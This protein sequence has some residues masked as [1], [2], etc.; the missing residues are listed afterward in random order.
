MIR[1]LFLSLL[2]LSVGCEALTRDEAQQALDEVQ[3]SSQ[4]SAL[5]ASSVEISTHFTIGDAV[6]QAAEELRSFVQSQ[7]PCAEIALDGATL[8]IEYGANPGM[9]V[10][11]GQT[12]AGTHQISVM[13]NEMDDVVVNHTWTDFQNQEVKVNG[14]ATVTWSFADKERH[15]V[16]E[17]TWER[18][19]DGRTGTGSGDRIQ[20]P[21]GGGLLEGFSVD[22]THSWKGK[23][24]NWHLDIDQVEMRWIDPVPQDGTYTLDTPFDKAVSVDF[25]RISATQIQVVISGPKKS[26]DFKVNTLP[27][28]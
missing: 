25:T 5:T 28:G 4:A 1:A 7:L 15:V 27:E 21:L 10:Y 22:G 3:L 8:T 17:A 20:K 11:R 23:S 9:C 19:S 16:H 24:G 12:Y 13:N 26:F 14:T 6:E 18:M 2:L